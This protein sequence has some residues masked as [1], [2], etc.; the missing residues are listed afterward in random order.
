MKQ[1]NWAK[2]KII[3]PYE[4][5]S[6]GKGLIE[7]KGRLSL[8]GAQEKYSAILDNGNFRLTE[9]GERGTFILK[10]KLTGF[11]YRE[12]SPANEHLTMQ[13][14]AQVYNIQTAENAICYTQNGEQVY[15]T[16]RYDIDN[17]GNKIQQEDFASL[18]GISRATHGNNYKYDALN[19]VDLAR[20]IQ[21]Y[22]P[23]WRIELIKFFDLMLFNFVFANGDA[24][25]KNFSVLKTSRG[26][27][28]LSPAYDLINT[29]IHI[30]DSYIF[31]LEKGLYP[32][33]HWKKGG[34]GTDFFKFGT[35][36][37]LNPKIA[38]MEI[39]RFCS[40][41]SLIDK[42]INDSSLSDKLK[43]YYTT[44]YQTRINSYLKCR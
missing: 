34:S 19:Y 39:D 40:E 24:H 33:W 43:E 3:L 20:I 9:E 11:N 26:D 17:N 30:P 7:N 6:L 42:L 8:S 12:F 13:I 18:A 35:M 38:R 23:A 2:N 10:P 28:R 4:S 5:L 41:Y 27:Y 14:A 22:I 31:A 32:G 29:L 16:K 1:Y 25:I 44:I 21:K 36:I 37:G 15:I